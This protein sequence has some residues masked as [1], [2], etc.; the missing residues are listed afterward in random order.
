MSIEYLEEHRQRRKE[1]L[2]EVPANLIHAYSESVL[3]TLESSLRAISQRNRVF[4][5]INSSSL[6]SLR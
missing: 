3:T 5:S 4:E 1:L 2:G 6:H